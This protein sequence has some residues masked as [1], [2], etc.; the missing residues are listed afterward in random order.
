MLH[1]GTLQLHH[2]FPSNLHLLIR[3]RLQRMLQNIC[4]K[5][6]PLPFVHDEA[7]SQTVGSRVCKADVSSNGTWLWQKFLV[8]KP[9]TQPCSSHR[10]SLPHL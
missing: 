8:Y 3:H 7:G 10:S 9:A 5:C 4:I 6:D 2:T 1:K